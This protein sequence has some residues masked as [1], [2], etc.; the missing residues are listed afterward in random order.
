MLKKVISTMI[1]VLLFSTSHANVTIYTPQECILEKNGAFEAKYVQ[2]GETVVFIFDRNSLNS[3]WDSIKVRS[4]WPNSAQVVDRAIR[5]TLEVPPT[6][7]PG[8]KNTE[9]TLRDERTGVEESYNLVVYVKN[10]LIKVGINEAHI[11]CNVGDQ[12]TYEAVITNESLSKHVVII[13][14]SLPE[15]WFAVQRISLEPKSSKVVSLNV[16]AFTPGYKRFKFKVES[17]LFEKEFAEKEVTMKIIPSLQSKYT[18]AI[19]SLPFFSMS[20]LPGYLLNAILGFF[21]T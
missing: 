7:T 11:D 16:N 15:T 20:L 8:V 17:A 6:E 2:P 19:Y 21:L 4:P 3:H 18:V 9:V 10:D 1:I 13:R 14:S 5:L 12:A